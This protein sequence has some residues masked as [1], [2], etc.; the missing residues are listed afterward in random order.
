MTASVIEDEL[1][2]QSQLA[3]VNHSATKPIFLTSIAVDGDN[4]LSPVSNAL[5]ES[6][7][8]PV[9]SQPLQTLEH[10]LESLDEVREKIMYTGL[11]QEV[12]VSLDNDVSAASVDKLKKSFPE[13]YALEY[14]LPSIAKINLKPLEYHKYSVTSSTSDTFSSLGGRI[15]FINSLGR[16]E[17]LVVQGDARYTPFEGKI[18]EQSVNTKLLLPL[19]K[20][21]SLKAVLDL[22]Y[23]KLDFSNQPFLDTAD[24]H[25]QNQ[26]S[27]S[28]GVQKHWIS[29][30]T[31][32]APSL[33]TG[34][35]M[36]ARNVY[37]FKEP[38]AVSDSIKQFN[39]TFVK[40]SFITQFLHDSRKFFGLFPA[41]GSKFAIKNEY[42]LAQNFPNRKEAV[43]QDKNFDKLGISYE[44]HVPFFKSLIV[45]S[46]SFAY[47][48]IF[49]IGEPP[50]VVHTMDK[51]YLGGL[52]TLKGFERNSIGEHGGH[53]YCKLALASSFKIPNTPANSPLRM[54]FF[55]NAGDVFNKGPLPQSLASSSGISLIYKTALANMDL[56]YAVPLSNRITDGHKPGFSFGVA[57]SL[58]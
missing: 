42:V 29:K 39:G 43:P 53:F 26:Y 21:P 15:S 32:A 16:A 11:F 51:F 56:T 3:Y 45:N 7:L 22:T 27:L 17:S 37:G 19:Q 46:M 18:D 28:L 40:N 2:K 25:K 4:K 8:D 12:T 13:D 6:I 23:A 58:Y 31:E 34:V 9:L 50:A 41:S 54:Q 38:N 24:E 52:A 55:L 30:R 49:Q 47:G 57:L 33:F 10:T 35:T 48:G 44:K 14:P 1:K 5:F 36:V 20:N